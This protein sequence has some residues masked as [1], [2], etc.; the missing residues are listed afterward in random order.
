MKWLATTWNNYTQAQSID[1][2]TWITPVNWHAIPALFIADCIELS[3]RFM[4]YNDI[5][6]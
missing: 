1:W 3:K 4:N 5:Y 6:S 2:I